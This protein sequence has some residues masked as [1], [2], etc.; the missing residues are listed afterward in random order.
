MKRV[1]VI[2][3][4]GWGTALALHLHR[5]GHG[6][7]V[8]SPFEAAAAEVAVSRRNERFLPGIEIPPGI[9][10]TAQR[11]QAVHKAEVIL[12]V[13]PTRYF[14]TVLQ[15]FLPFLPPEA[16]H[17]SAAKGLEE[18]T[19]LRMTEVAEDLIR[20]GPGVALSGPTFAEEVA[21]GLPAAAVAACRDSARAFAAQETLGGESFRVYTSEDVVG[22]EL[23]GALK[24]VI[25]L[26]AGVCDGIG[27]GT[28][29]RAALITRGL[30]EIARL[31][32]ALGARAETFAG[33]SGMGDLVLTCTGSLSRNRKVGERLGR[34]ERLEDI[35]GGMVQVA[36]G[37]AAARNALELSRRVRVAMPIV[38]EVVALL[39][40]ERD[41]RQAVGGLMGRALRSESDGPA[42]KGDRT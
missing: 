26:A 27:A 36:E 32:L 7:S 38:Q 30:A 6:V 20:G 5:A 1:A 31:G 15:S 23:G 35:L 2:G 34:G 18:G 8:W 33:L 19:L 42:P 22:V 4:G 13:V 28:N 24:N 41:P 16:L 25:A 29:A 10:W 40:G 21:R 12:W 11:A 39:D 14:R 9:R 37:V 3:D 17:I